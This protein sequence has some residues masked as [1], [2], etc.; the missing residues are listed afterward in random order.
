[1]IITEPWLHWY[2][3]LAAY[4]YATLQRYNVRTVVESTVEPLSLDEAYWHLHID[5]YGSP[6]GSDHDDWLENIG[7]PG[8]RSW[9]EA[10]L[11]RTI[12]QQTLEL[13]SDQ[14]PSGDFIDLPFGPV[15]SIESVTYL[16]DGGND[17]VFADTDYTLDNYS[18]PHRLYLGYEMEWPE[19]VRQVRNSVRIRYVVGYSLSGES[20]PG[21]FPLPPK[22]R[23]GMLMLLGHMFR[24][25]ENTTVLKLDQIP[26]GVQSFLDWDRVRP[27][28]V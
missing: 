16:D 5:T 9:C 14:F 17:V 12:A 18:K 6:L 3:S 28:F 8:A 22:T 4:R 24:N 10:Y 23:I 25:R 7:I 13:S 19:V 26:I 27:H 2:D 20:P 11:E 15:L 21:E 1:M